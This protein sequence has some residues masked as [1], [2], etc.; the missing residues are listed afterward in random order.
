MQN[1]MSQASANGLLSFFAPTRQQ[2]A[3]QYVVFNVTRE[4]LVEDT[5]REICMYRP[6]DLK[7]PLKV[8]F[9]GE[10]AEDAGGV[11]KVFFCF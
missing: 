3:Q 9:H 7:K 11:R 5:L 4:H 10:E 8:K 1:A 2:D 6:Q